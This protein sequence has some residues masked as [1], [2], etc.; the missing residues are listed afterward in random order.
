MHPVLEAFVLALPRAY[1]SMRAP[2][3]TTVGIVVTGS[4]GGTWYL[5]REEYRWRFAEPEESLSAEVR[6]PEDLA[7]RL[8]VRQILPADAASDIER[9]GRSDLCEPA[10]RAVAVMTSVA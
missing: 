3:G 1:D 8:Y 7:W 2:I 9:S 5:R 4:S 10:C 6:I